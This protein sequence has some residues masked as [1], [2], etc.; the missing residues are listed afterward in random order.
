MTNQKKID[1]IGQVET[2]NFPELDGLQLKSRV[3]TGAQTSSIWASKI[4]IVDGKLKVIF[5]CDGAPGYSGKMYTFR[6][7]STTI[8]V[9]S[10]GHHE[11][12]YK[13]K[14]SVNL[15]GRRINAN[16]TLADRSAQ[17]YPVL[18]GRNVLRGKFVVDVRL[19]SPLVSAKRHKTAK[20]LKSHKDIS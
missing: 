14:L 15:L 10:N 11:Q 6:D 3:D 18:I 17:V 19:G 20:L 2:I 9:S 5:L 8:V 4:E 1:T 13:I 12:R 16:F 7:Y